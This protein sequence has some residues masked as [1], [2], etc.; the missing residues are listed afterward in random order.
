V[1]IGE[2]NMAYTKEQLEALEDAIS[3][4]VTSVSYNGKTITYRSLSEMIKIRDNMR[5]E[6]GVSAKKPRSYRTSFKSG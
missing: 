2:D 4:G 6:L 1:V 3:Q 5:S